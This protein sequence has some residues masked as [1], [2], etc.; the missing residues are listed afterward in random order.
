MRFKRADYLLPAFPGAALFL[1]CVAE[2]Y[3][4][5]SARPRWLT[6]G[7]ATLVLGCVLGWWIYRTKSLARHEPAREL[8]RFAVEIR[9]HVTTSP[10]TQFPS[11]GRTEFIPFGSV[12]G[13]RNEYLSTEAERNEFRSTEGQR[14]KFRSTD[15]PNQ[16][17]PSLQPRP[18]VVLFW[19]E[20]HTLAFHL[21]RPLAIF[22]EWERLEKLAAQAEP[23]YVVMP[24]EVAAQ[25]PRCL[26][27]GRLEEVF[28]NTDL[29]GAARHEKPLVLL[30]TRPGKPSAAP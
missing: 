30:R 23:T 16:F 28:R 24:P 6:A 9:R 12:A 4:R 14:N 2:R 1:G 17:S 20:N 29:P 22:V 27:S 25:W 15:D 5:E 8:R 11:P 21:G 10:L 26:T 7:F 3:Y 19:T 13:E 18:E